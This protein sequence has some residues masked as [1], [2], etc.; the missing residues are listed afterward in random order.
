MPMLEPLSSS[1][2]I[3]PRRFLFATWDG[4]GNLSPILALVAGL[5]KRVHSVN[6]LAHDVQRPKIENA[7]G[8]FFFFGTAAQIDHSRSLP[9]GDD[10]F[11][12]LAAIDKDAPKTYWPLLGS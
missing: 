8:I 4:A 1:T 2:A 12:T 11:A 3:K 6:V 10:P 7:G 5:A 9:F